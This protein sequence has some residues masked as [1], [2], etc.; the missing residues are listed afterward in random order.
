MNVH[1]HQIIYEQKWT[2]NN[3]HADFAHTYT[4][5]TDSGRNRNEEE[6]EKKIRWESRV[7]NTKWKTMIATTTT[8]RAI[9]WQ[10][11]KRRWSRN[12]DDF[13]LHPLDTH[14]HTFLVEI[15][16]RAKNE[17]QLKW[18]NVCVNKHAVRDGDNDNDKNTNGK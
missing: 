15:F 3:R 1:T 7:Q 13:H 6:E 14:S 2:L 16:A 17:S 9:K 4:T 10:T 18:T 12:S 5:A 8:T 11:E